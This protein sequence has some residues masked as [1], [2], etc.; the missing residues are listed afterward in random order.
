MVKSPQRRAVDRHTSQKQCC[1][2]SRFTLIAATRAERQQVGGT[3]L[4]MLFESMF[5]R[6]WV[7]EQQFEGEEKEE[8]TEP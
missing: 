8:K 2:S 7:F 6:E 3:G 1:A 4:R 5:P